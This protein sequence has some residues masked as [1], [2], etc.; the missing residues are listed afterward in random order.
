MKNTIQKL[1]ILSLMLCA[2][3]IAIAAQTC[4]PAPVNLI[5]WWNA[6]NNALDSRS[7]SNGTLTGTTFVAGQNGQGIRFA[8]PLNTDN[9]SADGSGALDLTGNQ[10]TLEAWIKLENNSLQPAQAF[11][12][13]IVCKTPSM[14]I[15]VD[16]VCAPVFW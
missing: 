13:I 3:S 5:S 7:R 4:A 2:S 6:D 15:L 10:V 11:T 14:Y 12:A 1:L 16:A 9:F 8:A